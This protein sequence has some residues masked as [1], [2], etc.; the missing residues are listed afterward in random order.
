MVCGEAASERREERES[1]G[2]RAFE[3][4]DE[5]VEG[6]RWI[7]EENTALDIVTGEHRE[8]R[9]GEL[10]GFQRGFVIRI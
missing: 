9:D 3:K 8:V 5:V 2:K 7:R 6:V 1:G 10:E 4:C